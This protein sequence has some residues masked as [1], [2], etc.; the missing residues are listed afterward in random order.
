MRFCLLLLLF[1]CGCGSPEELGSGT[2]GNTELETTPAAPTGVTTMAADRQDLLVSEA[3]KGK[4]VSALFGI[5]GFDAE[6]CFHQVPGTDTFLAIP[7]AVA[8]PE[9]GAQALAVLAL[10]KY[11]LAHP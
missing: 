11:V 5:P 6:L 10:F 3:E 8:G 7:E 4:I 1:L 9:N 2:L